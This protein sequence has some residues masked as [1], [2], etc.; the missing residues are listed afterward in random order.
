MACLVARLLYCAPGGSTRAA[1]RGGRCGRVPPS[2]R[3]PPAASRRGA[4]TASAPTAGAAPGTT[5]HMCMGLQACPDGK[6]ASA[7]SQDSQGHER[8]LGRRTGGGGCIDVTAQRRAHQT[9]SAGEGRSGRRQQSCTYQISWHCAICSAMRSCAELVHTQPAERLSREQLCGRGT[10]ANSL[11]R[12]CTTT[13][14]I[15]SMSPSGCP[16][17]PATTRVSVCSGPELRQV[18]ASILHPASRQTAPPAGITYLHGILAD[19][20]CYS[21][22]SCSCHE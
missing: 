15:S 14:G 20:D 19:S 9:V 12:G 2:A 4:A 3:S 7:T 13:V 1:G 5:A 18:E 11:W 21:V 8:M 22:A 16:L 10:L 6:T 17:R